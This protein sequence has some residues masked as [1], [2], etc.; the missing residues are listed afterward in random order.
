MKRL[1]IELQTDTGD[2]ASKSFLTGKDLNDLSE[3]ERAISS[4][5]EILT[6]DIGYYSSDIDM[7]LRNISKESE[8]RFDDIEL[9]LHPEI[10]FKTSE[11]FLNKI[12]TDEG[13]KAF[14]YDF[15]KKEF[16]IKG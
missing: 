8:S 9:E 6:L 4:L 12:N 13:F 2:V 16:S 5:Y 11:E 14:M 10:D 7:V 3:I 15:Y 1:T